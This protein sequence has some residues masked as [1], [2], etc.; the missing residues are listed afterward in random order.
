MR[1]SMVWPALVILLAV[2]WGCR[3][4]PGSGIQED[5]RPTEFRGR[6][7]VLGIEGERVLLNHDEIPGFMDAMSMSFEV[8]DPA[9]LEGLE[10]GQAV[11]FRLITTDDGGS[12]FIDQL[13]VVAEADNRQ[14]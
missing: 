14:N 7:T 1:R 6:G 13:E 3:Q 5:S 8:R 10:A 11:T 4:D 12:Y 2:G 9:L